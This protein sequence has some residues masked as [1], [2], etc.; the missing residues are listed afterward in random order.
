VSSLLLRT[1]LDVGGEELR[2][3]RRLSA[4]VKAKDDRE[5]RAYLSSI[6]CQSSVTSRGMES[7]SGDVPNAR[8]G[9]ERDGLE[10][11]G[12]LEEVVDEKLRRCGALNDEESVSFGWVELSKDDGLKDEEGGRG[13]RRVSTWKASR[14]SGRL[15]GNE[16]PE[17]RALSIDEFHVD[18]CGR[19]LVRFRDRLRRASLQRRKEERKGKGESELGVVRL[20]RGEGAFKTYHRS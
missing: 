18:D 5:T 20:E 9:R 10:G 2:G 7:E 8:R 17:E 16:Q 14:K 19:Q 4:L 3:G 6:S 1:G 12:S 13:K 15:K 11:R